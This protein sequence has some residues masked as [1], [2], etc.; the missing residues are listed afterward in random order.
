MSS[1]V[2]ETKIEARESKAKGIP[3]LVVPVE[4]DTVDG[5]VGLPVSTVGTDV[6]AD[7][8]VGVSDANFALDFKSKR[9]VEM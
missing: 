7:T 9:A 5:T 4:S 2:G 8:V 1:M 6:G 3:E